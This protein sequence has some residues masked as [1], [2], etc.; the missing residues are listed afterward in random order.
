MPIVIEGPDGAG[1][2]TPAKPSADR[3]D[4]NILKMTAIITEV[5]DED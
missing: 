5:N 1:R 4:M 3:L 2:S